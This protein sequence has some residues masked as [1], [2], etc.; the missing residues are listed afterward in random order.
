M[1]HFQFSYG[2]LPK[3]RPL[4]NHATMIVHHSGW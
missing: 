4:A 1:T 3:R 2:S